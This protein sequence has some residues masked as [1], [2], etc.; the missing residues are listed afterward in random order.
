MPLRSGVYIVPTHHWYIE[1]TVWLIAGG[2]LLGST[3]LAALVDP[4]WILG[5][6]ATGLASILV[7]LTGFC[8]VG[9][10][11]ARLGFT[12]MLGRPDWKPGRPYFIQTD[13]WYLERRIYLAVGINISLASILSLVHS[14]WWLLF[15]G[16][17]GTAMVWFAATGFCIMANGLF[18]LGAE[19]RL[20][21]LRE[22]GDLAGGRAEEH[23]RA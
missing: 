6:T 13:S 16:F 7:A 21:P 9:N 4:L 22:A 20:A 2:V 14:P 5:V 10:V 23:A 17:V 12:P 3:L 11:L 18:W 19:P 8:L 15:T 1:R